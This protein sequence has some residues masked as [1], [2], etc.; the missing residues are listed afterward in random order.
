M[1]CNITVLIPLY[2][3]IEYLP[4]AIH[5]VIGQSH[6][7][8]RILIGING[9]GVASPAIAEQVQKISHD[10]RIQIIIQPPEINN[11]SKSLN[12]LITLVKTEWVA[13]L[14]ADDA[15]LPKK[16]EAQLL[17]LAEN[18]QC[19]VIGTRCEYFGNLSGS[20]QLPLGL[21]PRKATLDYNPI[22]NSSVLFKT[23]YARWNELLSTEG[24]EDY[25]LWL[26]LDLQGVKMY[27]VP[28]ILVRHRIHPESFFNTR[29]GDTTLLKARFRELFNKQ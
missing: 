17:A 16:L 14:D 9:H 5:S 10:P 8:W 27:N 20:P 19:E 12:H 15:W 13:L 21:I 26:T 3:G 11:K 29:T 6:S 23:K 24:Y 25:E 4:E 18:P 2:N 1:D 22:I 7:D 28:H